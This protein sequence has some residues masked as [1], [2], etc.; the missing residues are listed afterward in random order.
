[1]GD[2]SSTLGKKSKGE[3]RG[4]EKTNNKSEDPTAATD[5]SKK[6]PS[7]D[8]DTDA[9][10]ADLEKDLAG[11]ALNK[12]EDQRH[13]HVLN[14]LNLDGVIEYIKQGKAKNVIVMA[15]AGISTS[16]G[17]PDFRSPGTGLYD[18]LQKYNLPT[19]SAVFDIEY[20][21]ENPKPFFVLAKDIYPEDLTP[22]PT[23]HF[24]KLLEEKNVLLRHYT[25]NIDTLERVAGLS[26]E[27]LV[28]AHGTF[29]SSHCRKCNKEYSASWMRSL[30]FA[31]KIPRCEL[32]NCEGVVK[33][34]IV[35]FGENLPKRFFTCVEEDFNKCDL[36]LIMGSSLVVQPFAQL[37]DVVPQE[38]PRLLINREVA[39]E[40]FSW[41]VLG[42][43]LHFNHPDNF[44]DV[45]KEGDTDSTCKLMATKLGWDLESKLK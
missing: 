30:I 20:F 41:S 3:E 15:G 13:P 35:F 8:K 24:I 37:I 44:R 28:E 43:G 34:D 11:I 22:T 10:V 7:K 6:T 18:N 38:C 31:E 1:M 4:D 33:P 25:Q 40:S 42:S 14:E 23:H 27:K 16:A 12:D 21:D 2:K 39:G 19:P 32:K 36:L 5:N 9:G 17:I 45:F 29:H 26:P